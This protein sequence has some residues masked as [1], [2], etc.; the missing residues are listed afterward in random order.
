MTGYTCPAEGCDYEAEETSSV[1]SHIN[2]KSGP[3][4]Q[5]K[6]ALRAALA[7]QADESSETSGESEGQQGDDE[8]GDGPPEGGAE[9][10]EST[11]SS[12][13][14]P[15]Q[16]DEQGEAAENKE[17]DHE[18]SDPMP[19]DD[20]LD[21]QRAQV[22]TT[23]D[24]GDEGDQSTPSKGEK[25]AQPAP[26]SGGIPLPV[27]STT[28][29]AGVALVVMLVVLWSYLRTEGDDQP[30]ETDDETT[31]DAPDDDPFVDIDT[32]DW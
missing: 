19:T 30:E 4:H 24:Q 27:S 17:N 13:D 5:D 2:A 29:I 8:Q 18:E 15:E 11:R 26:S 22:T 14:D 7:E 32:E 28:L 23:D 20:E 3:E 12:D 21:R 9:G 31:A 6:E 16:G 1:I 25:Q 10:G